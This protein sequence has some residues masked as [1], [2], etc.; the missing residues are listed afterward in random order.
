M[1]RRP[2]PFVRHALLGTLVAL[3]AAGCA[4]GYGSK[5]LTGG[6]TDSRIDDIH[7]LV[8]FNGN[9]FASKDRVW[10]FWFYR[11]AELTVEKGFTYFDLEPAKKG[12]KQSFLEDPG[13]ASRYAGFRPAASGGL[14]VPA[15]YYYVPGTTVTT[16]NSS[17]VVVMFKTIP[18]GK[19]LFDARRVVELLDPYVKSNGSGG[20]PDRKALIRGAVMKLGANQVA[21]RI[22]PDGVKVAYVDMKRVL[23]GVS[24]GKAALARL[25]ATISKRQAEVDAG[26]AEL[27]KL[28][29]AYDAEAVDAKRT[30]IEADIAARKK[31]LQQVQAR[32]QAEL[33]AEEK[34][35]VGKITERAGPLVEQVR[36]AQHLD[37]VTEEPAGGLWDADITDEVIRRYEEKYPV[38]GAA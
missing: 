6:Y 5:G 2:K 33:S 3:A 34:K 26:K 27:D 17:A 29:K 22:F 25:K 36:S 4:T 20:L 31:Q 37:T 38:P 21:E 10:N 19:A 8:S 13:A 32:Y 11:C 28:R 30:A 15:G 7:Y 12:E 1:S 9:G 24:E 18:A 14:V 23:N 35:A 16:W